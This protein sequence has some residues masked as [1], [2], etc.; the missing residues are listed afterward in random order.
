[1]DE[2]IKQ[3][4]ERAGIPE[5]KARTAVNTVMGFLQERLPASIAGQIENVTTNVGGGVA[6]MA[7]NVI[8][9]L[10]SMLGGKKD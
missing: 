1:M 6:D 10:G 8:G 2:L 3:V 9:D 5:D 4:A 7:G